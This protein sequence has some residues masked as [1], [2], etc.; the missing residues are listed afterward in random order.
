VFTVWTILEISTVPDYKTTR[1]WQ[2]GREEGR[3]EK[4]EKELAILSAQD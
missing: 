4:R 3:K 1:R 2:G